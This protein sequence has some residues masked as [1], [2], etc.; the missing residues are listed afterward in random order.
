MESEWNSLQCSPERFA[1]GKNDFGYSMPDPPV[2]KKRDPELLRESGIIFQYFGLLRPLDILQESQIFQR[3]QMR[4]SQHGSTL[5]EEYI[6]TSWPAA[7]L[8]KKTHL[9]FQ[10]MLSIQ[11]CSFQT[12][13]GCPPSLSLARS[14]WLFLEPLVLRVK[15]LN[16][17]SPL[18]GNQNPRVYSTDPTEARFTFPFLSHLRQCG[19]RL[20]LL[21]SVVFIS[22]E[23]E[24]TMRYF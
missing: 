10:Q 16:T 7:T 23:V 11:L 9:S 12:S 5:I 2:S 18:K 20:F 21:A 13:S 6:G 22:E 15:C 3:Q 4:A 24:W 14:A 8:K 19:C 17:K 1:Y